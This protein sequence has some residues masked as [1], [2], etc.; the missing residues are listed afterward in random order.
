MS[1][2]P[3]DEQSLIRRMLKGDEAAFETFY[4][5]HAHRLFRF[6]AGRLGGDADWAE[7]V[8]QRSMCIAM[9]KLHTFRGEAAVYT[10]L[11]TI[12]RRE[13]AADFKRI[14]R[15]PRPV[16]LAE[17]EPEIRAALESLSAVD[18]PETHAQR[19]EIARRVHVALDH[20][21]THYGNALEWKYIIGL[22]VVE[23][24]DRLGTKPKAAESLLTRA[25]SAF[26]EAY[27]ALLKAGGPSLVTVPNGR[28]VQS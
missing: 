10:W 27:T 26:R 9:D 14:D 23:I 22:S 15:R 12:C 4:E 21:P 8:V 2:T 11:C 18:D 24:A 1:W 17:D 5:G 3:T 6:A 20:L 28:G 16:E 13:I 19:Q 25:R 7:D